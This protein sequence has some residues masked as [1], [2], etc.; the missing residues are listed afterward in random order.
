MPVNGINGQ[1]SI[2]SVSGEK[3]GVG[4]TVSLQFMF[5]E[6][7]MELAKAAKESAMEKMDQIKASQDERK[8]V[9][10]FLNECRQQ[11]AHDPFF[12][13]ELLPVL[14]FSL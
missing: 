5:A 6:L 1:S 12:H 14:F 9:S 7:Q 10:A 13:P 2:S 3:M 8:Q 11:Q 4:N